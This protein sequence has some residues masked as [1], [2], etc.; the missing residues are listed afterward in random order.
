MSAF[1]ATNLETIKVKIHD[2]LKKVPQIDGPLTQASEASKIDKAFI[3][4]AI[5]A[6]PVLL[7]FIMDLGHIIIDMIGFLYPMY[8]SVKALE[9]DGKEDDSQWLMYWIIFG[10]VKIF[11]TVFGFLLPIIPF[12]Y[13]IKVLLLIWCYHPT[14]K[15]ARIVYENVIKPTFNKY[16]AKEEKQKN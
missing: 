10:I 16:F 13:M 3:V 1:T 11:E 15:G 4:L 14:T 9:T 2:L 7:A 12:Y 8:A 5:L 6:V